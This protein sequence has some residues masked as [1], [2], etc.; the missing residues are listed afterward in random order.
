MRGIPSLSGNAH[1]CLAVSTAVVPSVICFTWMILPFPKIPE[2]ESPSGSVDE[3]LGLHIHPALRTEAATVVSV[4]ERSGCTSLASS[5][6]RDSLLSDHTGESN[7][8]LPQKS[9]WKRPEDP[10]SQHGNCKRQPMFNLHWG[11]ITHRAPGQGA[12]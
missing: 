10:P 1:L 7:T 2:I 3:N 4:H 9:E 11:W 5:H 12:S 8:F 6:P